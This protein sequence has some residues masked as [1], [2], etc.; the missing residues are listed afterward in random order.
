MEPS[1]SRSSAQRA[2]VRATTAPT[3]QRADRELGA[4]GK[5]TWREVRGGDGDGGSDKRKK[6]DEDGGEA[7]VD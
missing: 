2:A 5:V 6:R 1:H 4:D 7:H 3:L